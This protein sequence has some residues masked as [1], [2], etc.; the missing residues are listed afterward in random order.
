MTTL[1]VLILRNETLENLARLLAS[2]L[3]VRC[4]TGGDL[5]VDHFAGCGL[6]QV[7]GKTIL[8]ISGKFL[9][10]LHGLRKFCV[11]V[12]NDDTGLFRCSSAS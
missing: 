12:V 8:P 7:I 1:F 9:N 10:G 6:Q 4:F 3:C 11:R 5:P 2:F